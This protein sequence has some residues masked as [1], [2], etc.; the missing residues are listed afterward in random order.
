MPCGRT[1]FVPLKN[2]LVIVFRQ[3]VLNDRKST[4]HLVQIAYHFII[5]MNV[6]ELT[7]HAIWI[8]FAVST[9]WCAFSG[10]RL[11]ILNF[12]A[13]YTSEC[14]RCV[15]AKVLVIAKNT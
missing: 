5:R 7:G 10:A 14:E 9:F 11:R 12:Q 2:R 1:R 4:P 8:S 15:V 3:S 6:Q 13:G